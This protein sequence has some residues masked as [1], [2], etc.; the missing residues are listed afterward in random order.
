[1]QRFL[2]I[3]QNFNKKN[4]LINGLVE[5]IIRKTFHPADAYE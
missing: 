2:E 5:R 3:V 1:M 4:K